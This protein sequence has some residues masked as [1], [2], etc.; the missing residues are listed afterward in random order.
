M[1]RLEAGGDLLEQSFAAVRL[2]DFGNREHRYP[3][4]RRRCGPQPALCKALANHLASRRPDRNRGTRRG[5]A[6]APG[7]CRREPAGVSVRAL[8]RQPL[9]RL[10]VGLLALTVWALPHAARACS[11]LLAT[12]PRDGRGAR[13]RRV[14]G[15]RREHSSDLSSSAGAGLVRYDLEVLR[16]WKGELKPAAQLTSRASSAACGRSLT[17][18]KVYL[19]YASKQDD[20]QLTDN[21]CSRT[22][23][24]STA[25]EDLAVLGP[26]NAPG[27]RPVAEPTSREPPRIAPPPPDLGR[28]DPRSRLADRRLAG[29][30]A[31]RGRPGCSDSRAWMLATVLLRRRSRSPRA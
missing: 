30:P 20:G 29:A 16:Q 23:L 19:I 28:P 27:N 9:P 12:R 6:S 22:R 21:R 25:D 1:P 10:A 7:A 31:S 17:V 18:G 15:P 26:G 14:R 8:P 2:G 24:A 11:C 4:P 3:S 13:R 5:L